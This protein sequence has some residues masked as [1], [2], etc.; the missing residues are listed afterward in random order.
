MLRKTKDLEFL[1]NGRLDDLLEAVFGMA[2]A[3]LARM[4]VMR[5]GHST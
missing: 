5:K 1:S 4:A 3:E 2:W